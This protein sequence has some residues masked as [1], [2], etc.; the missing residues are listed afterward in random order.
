M[1]V[2]RF[3]FDRVF[4]F[5]AAP[6][7][8]PRDDGALA[9]R[10]A[11]LEAELDRLGAAHP[12]DLAQ[13]R[14]D[15]F[16]AG[17]AQARMEREAAILAA[18]DALQASLEMMEDRLAVAETAMMRDMAA[19]SFTAAEVIAGHSVDRSPARAVDEALGR[20]LTQVSRGTALGIR[21]HPDIAEAVEGLVTERKATERRRLDIT[22][23][24]DPALAPGDGTIFW[25]EGGLSVD[26]QSRRAAVMAELGPLL[27][28]ENPGVSEENS[29]LTARDER[30]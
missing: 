14:S 18:T 29:D 27:A 25:E 15:G 11:S 7:E 21:V 4:R 13:A 6:D 30:I 23:L 8:K 10:I 22:V 1:N 20:L 19:L 16:A 2:Q 24:S 5:P 28:V 17:L 3:G 26:A 12:R 9:Q